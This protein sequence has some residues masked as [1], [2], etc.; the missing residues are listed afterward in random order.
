MVG[1]KQ[2]TNS[3]IKQQAM[4]KATNRKS[5]YKSQKRKVTKSFELKICAL[6]WRKGEVNS[7]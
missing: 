2:E 3:I 4:A 5:M 7:T 1:E 6:L